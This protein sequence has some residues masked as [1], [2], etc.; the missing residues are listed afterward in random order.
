MAHS[1]ESLQR[2]GWRYQRATESL[3]NVARG[4]WSTADVLVVTQAL[5][6][7]P[8]L[9]KDVQRLSRDVNRLKR[10]LEEARA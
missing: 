7:M 1:N 5:S 6:D 2:V 3:G 4:S 8:D 9:I 10:A